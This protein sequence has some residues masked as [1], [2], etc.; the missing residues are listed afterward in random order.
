VTVQPEKNY[1]KIKTR[2]QP[3]QDNQNRTTMKL[4]CLW[5]SDEKTG[6][7]NIAVSAVVQ[8]HFFG[9]C[10]EISCVLRKPADCNY[11]LAIVCIFFCAPKSI[12]LFSFVQYL[13]VA[14]GIEPAT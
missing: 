6:T 14:A 10:E 13:G 4:K 8:V 3:P 12:F 5:I 1:N 7:L 2:G 11:Y 9:F